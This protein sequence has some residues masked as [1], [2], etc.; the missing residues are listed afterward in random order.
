MPNVNQGARIA[1]P[2]S[3]KE[4]INLC[5]PGTKGQ[6]H[7]LLMFLDAN[8]GALTHTIRHACGIRNLSDAVGHLNQK[9]SRYG[10]QVVHETPEIFSRTQRGRSMQRHWRIA[11]V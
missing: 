1:A 10:W 8:P 11:R 4:A 7:R 3:K 2:L 5:L 9:L 6:G